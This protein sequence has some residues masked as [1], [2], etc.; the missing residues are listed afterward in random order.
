MF[1]F[2]R[3]KPREFNYIP[4]YFNIEE[5]ERDVKKRSKGV[6]SDKDN[7]KYIPGSIIKQ[8]RVRRMLITEEDKDANK[9]AIVIRM[10]VFLAL[11]LI[12]AYFLVTY[13]G[14]EAMIEVFQKG[15]NS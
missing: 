9:R 3:Q 13:T 1:G 6:Y 12:A 5:E 10:V 8:G 14:F 2:N 4:R 15:G 11:L 7:E